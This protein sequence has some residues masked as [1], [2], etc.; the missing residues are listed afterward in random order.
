M[1]QTLTV[2]RAV[3]CPPQKRPQPSERRARSD[4]PYHRRK[5]SKNAWQKRGGGY[6][7][8]DSSDADFQPFGWALR[9]GALP[10]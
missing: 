3:P 5:T 10:A 6:I 9:V 4:A 2:G 7:I 1:E 8:I